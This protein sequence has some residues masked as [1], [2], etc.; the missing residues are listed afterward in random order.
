M[1]AIGRFGELV[2][3]LTTSQVRVQDIVSTSE[4]SGQ[5]ADNLETNANK[6][7]GFQD[8]VNE[9]VRLVVNNDSSLQTSTTTD[10]RI[11]RAM[12]IGIVYGKV[13]D[14]EMST[15]QNK[16]MHLTR[17]DDLPVSR[18]KGFEY[19]V[20]FEEVLHIWDKSYDAFTG[21]SHLAYATRRTSDS[22]LSMFEKFLIER[23]GGKRKNYKDYSVP[24]T[25][26][27][28]DFPGPGFVISGIRGNPFS[29]NFLSRSF[30]KFLDIQDSPYV[31]VQKSYMN[32]IVESEN[33]LRDTTFGLF[34][35]IVVIRNPKIVVG[36]E[37]YALI[38]F[39]DHFH[40]EKS[41]EMA[42]LIPDKY[43]R[44]FL[45]NPHG[46]MNKSSSFYPENYGYRHKNNV[47]NLNWQ[48]VIAG[49][50]KA[51]PVGGVFYPKTTFYDKSSKPVTRDLLEFERIFKGK[52]TSEALPQNEEG[53]IHRT[54]MFGGYWHANFNYKNL[55]PFKHAHDEITKASLFAFAQ[56]DLLK[57]AFRIY[58]YGYDYDLSKRDLDE[59]D[60]FRLL[61]QAIEWRDSSRV[62]EDEKPLLVPVKRLRNANIDSDLL[63][64]VG[65]LNT[66]NM[67][68]YRPLESGNMIFPANIPS[69]DEDATAKTTW[70]QEGDTKNWGA[71][72]RNAQSAGADLMFAHPRIEKTLLGIMNSNNQERKQ[73]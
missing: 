26:T 33:S 9:F 15:F 44:E 58:C 62:R 4:T 38:V 49:M 70:T 59:K 29:K 73:Q 1:T 17:H 42:Y 32:M 43:A 3:K 46:R 66:R 27:I 23:N 16:F 53:H 48:S 40:N 41:Q 57:E 52:E 39:N 13:D 54:H 35:G 56:F 45:E 30:K 65:F 2:H 71:F 63:K 7:L 6:S 11:R 64:R 28:N 22:G 18:K 25:F 61:K 47:I 21:Y 72:R 68:C 12:M 24:N 34:R 69:E 37:R 31:R 20:T 10:W 60:K 36:G 19:N 55:K 50:D 14:S 67:V 8:A 51:L 5:A